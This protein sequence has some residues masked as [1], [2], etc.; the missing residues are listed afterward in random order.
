[1]HLTF[2]QIKF[3]DIRYNFFNELI[4]RRKNLLVVIIEKYMLRRDYS[5]AIDI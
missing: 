2:K 3:Y 5:V 4:F 1:M